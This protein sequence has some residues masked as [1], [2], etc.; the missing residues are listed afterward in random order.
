MGNLKYSVRERKWFY[1]L[2]LHFYFKLNDMKLENIVFLITKILRNI[3]GSECIDLVQMKE[4]LATHKIDGFSFNDAEIKNVSDFINLFD[5]MSNVSAS[6]WSKVYYEL[7]EWKTDEMLRSD[8]INHQKKYKNKC[9]NQEEIINHEMDQNEITIFGDM[10]KVSV[11]GDIDYSDS[12]QRDEWKAYRHRMKNVFIF[13]AGFKASRMRQKEFKRF[14]DI[15]GLRRYDLLVLVHEDL[16]SMDEFVLFF[17]NVFVNKKAKEIKQ[18]IETTKEWK[19]ILNALN[20]LDDFQSSDGMLVFEQFERFG[21]YLSLDKLDVRI[22]FHKIDKKEYGQIHIDQIFE[23]FKKKLMQKTNIRRKRNKKI[24]DSELEYSSNSN[25]KK[26]KNR[27][28]R[29]RKMKTKTY[30]FYEND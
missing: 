17:C 13:F 7:T 6:I 25:S 10:T 29:Y 18:H 9:G 24:K 11:R 27:R 14:L 12:Q 3:P 26:R 21:S 8:H 4:I 30:D 19:M 15:F 22:L 23:W 16:I 5:A 28:R 20:I 2:L 1:D